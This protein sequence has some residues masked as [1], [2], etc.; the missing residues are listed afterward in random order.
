MPVCL[1]RNST[2]DVI[3]GVSKTCSIGCKT[4]NLLKRNFIR[5][6]SQD[7][8]LSTFKWVGYELAFVRFANCTLYTCNSSEEELQKQP[9]D[10]FYE[11][12][13]FLKDLRIG[14]W[15]RNSI[16]LKR[17]LLRRFVYEFS[18]TFRTV[19][20]LNMPWKNVSSSNHVTS[21]K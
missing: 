17:T 4:S 3:L 12:K 19:D 20:F 7:K 21:I 18:K 15:T 11:K 16:C 10:V 2:R 6:N 13:L 9:P 5:G 14:G 1:W 8:F